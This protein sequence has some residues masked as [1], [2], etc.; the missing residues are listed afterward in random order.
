MRRWN[1]LSN[2]NELGNVLWYS[3]IY[4]HKQD[5]L[6]ISVVIIIMTG[7]RLRV[8]RSRKPSIETSHL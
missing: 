2:F 3:I 6:F 1:S 8:S 4:I 5:T 7:P